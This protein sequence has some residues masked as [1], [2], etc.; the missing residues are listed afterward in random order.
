MS[1]HNNAATFKPGQVMN[2]AGLRGVHRTWGLDVLTVALMAMAKAWEGQRLQY[3]GTLFPGI[4]EIVRHE[5]SLA[6]RAP[7]WSEG[8]RVQAI[9]SFLASKQ[10]MDWYGLVM[11]A[12]GDAPGTNTHVVS[13]QVLLKHWTA[14]HPGG[15]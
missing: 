1:K 10:Q 12:K 2:I 14:K 3:A 6:Q 13:G 7:R 8:P 15:A 11:R 5:R 9:A 4:A